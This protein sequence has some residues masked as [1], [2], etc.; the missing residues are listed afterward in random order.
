[1]ASPSSHSPDNHSP[2]T[3]LTGFHALAS[4]NSTALPHENEPR[5]RGSVALPPLE[6]QGF[7]EYMCLRYHQTVLVSSG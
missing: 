6:K 2:D 1:V 4:D 5:L 7:I 3:S